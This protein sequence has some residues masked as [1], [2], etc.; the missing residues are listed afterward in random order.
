MDYYDTFAE[1]DSGS[2][3]DT[4]MVKAEMLLG[5]KGKWMIQMFL[6]TD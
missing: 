5:V 6:Y 3:V 1:M 2:I 4:A